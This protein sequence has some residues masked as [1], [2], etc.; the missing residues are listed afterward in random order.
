MKM[1]PSSRLSNQN[2]PG[3]C[4]AWR[5]SAELVR[6]SSIA[7]CS[8]EASKR[9]GLIEIVY[10]GEEGGGGRLC[11]TGRDCCLRQPDTVDVFGGS[12]WTASRRRCSS[13]VARS[14]KCDSPPLLRVGQEY[15]TFFTAAVARV[16]GWQVV[17]KRGRRFVERTRTTGKNNGLF[18]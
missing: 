6:W 10:C 15:I 1:A 3:L 12:Y 5:W 16:F 11:G 14:L 8:S 9:A 4:V 2:T 17:G 7:A 13:R 18:F